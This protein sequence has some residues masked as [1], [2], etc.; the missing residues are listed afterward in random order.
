MQTS[1]VFELPSQMS[2]ARAGSMVPTA[3]M[4][5]TSDHTIKLLSIDSSCIE[6]E[7][8]SATDQRF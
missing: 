6:Q 1:P 4:T 5:Q 8:T 7:C 2:V 3:L